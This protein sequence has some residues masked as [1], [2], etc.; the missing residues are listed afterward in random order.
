MKTTLC[1]ILTLF[2]FTMLVFVPNSFAQDA[3]PEYVVRVIYFLPND[4]QPKPDI[5]KM[6]DRKIKEAQRFF[7][8]QLEVHG[9]DRRTFRI[10]ADDAGN[11]IVHHVNGRHDDAYYQNPSVGGS[12]S[13]VNEI[14]EQFDMSKNIYYIA[15]DSSSNFLD[16]GRATGWASG[17]GVSGVAFVTAFDKVPTIHE[18]GHAFGLLH[19]YR[20]NFKAK[21]VYTLDFHGIMTT[22]FCAAE[23]LYTHRYFNS[24][25]GEIN[26]NTEIQFHPSELIEPPIKIRLRFTLTD[27]DG[28]HQVQ[29]LYPQRFLPGEYNHLAGI[30]EATLA[31]C[32][33]LSGKRATVEF[34]THDLVGRNDATNEIAVTDK[35]FL[36]IIDVS[37][38]TTQRLF[39]LDITPLMPLH[40]VVSIPDKN[41]ALVIREEL[42]L[43]SGDPIT[44]L[45][46]LQLSK[47]VAVSHQITNLTGLESAIYLRELNLLDNQ[48]EDISHLSQ[49][50]YLTDISIGFNKIRDIT[51][52]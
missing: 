43:A 5:D 27:P 17:N 2:T 46:M 30:N 26:N 18:L 22:T 4:R 3:S 33:R 45:N 49:L 12:V 40:E 35:I 47:L 51:P 1:F 9:F 16:G 29:L 48:I 7:A 37:G 42:G 28:L 23:W 19:D 41:L 10:E 15:L 38:N 36:K 39:D 44:N 20:S 52:L 21:R 50:T 8:D 6:L 11:A 13:A 14:A 24:N 25:P 32:Q 31:A 34:V